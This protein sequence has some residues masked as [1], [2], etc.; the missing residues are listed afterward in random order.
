MDSSKCRTSISGRKWTVPVNYTVNVCVS[1]DEDASPHQICEN[2]PVPAHK[3]PRLPS[4]LLE[5]SAGLADAQPE[6]GDSDGNSWASAEESG[7]RIGGGCERE[8]EGHSPA[9]REATGCGMMRGAEKRGSAAW[10]GSQ[11]RSCMATRSRMEMCSRRGCVRA[12]NTQIRTSSRRTT[13]REV[14]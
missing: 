11:R 9:L 6:D 7:I 3:A 12:G 14:I 8:S 13:C 1:E 4:G 2:A 10:F 5:R